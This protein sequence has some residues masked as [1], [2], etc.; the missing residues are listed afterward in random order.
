MRSQLLSD[1]AVVGYEIYL[2][3]NNIKYRY[4]KP[5]NPPN[6]ARH[7]IEELRICK[8]D[9]INVLKLGNNTITPTENMQPGAYPTAIWRNPHPQGTPEARRTSLEL[10]IEAMLYGFSSMDHEQARRI[11]DMAHDVLAGRAKLAD[12]RH[13]LGLLH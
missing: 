1:L 12:F 5:G 11:N 6:N 3:G 2:E 10:V 7:L 13:L 8:A 9:V 4:R